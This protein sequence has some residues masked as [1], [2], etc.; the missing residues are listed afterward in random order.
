ML[1]F[2]KQNQLFLFKKP[3]DPT[4]P[5]LA[6]K[7]SHCFK[8]ST[9]WASPSTFFMKWASP[10]TFF[11]KWREDHYL[12]TQCAHH[13]QQKLRNLLSSTGPGSLIGIGFCMAF[14]TSIPIISLILILRVTWEL[15][16]YPTHK[17]DWTNPAHLHCSHPMALQIY[18][19][20]PPIYD[21]IFQRI[22]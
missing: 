21:E 20:Y 15:T 3:L 12:E 13:A 4:L 8:G 9:F 11:M 14:L 7:H 22:L 19:P 5:F 2:P 10:S 18:A 6:H 16:S 17:F 1:L